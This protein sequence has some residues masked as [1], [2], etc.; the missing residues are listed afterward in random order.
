MYCDFST[1]CSDELPKSQTLKLSGTSK[2]QDILPANY[3]IEHA[4]YCLIENK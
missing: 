4:I 3:I 1:F 2:S